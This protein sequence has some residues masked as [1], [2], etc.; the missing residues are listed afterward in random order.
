MN[1]VNRRSV[2]LA[3]LGAAG[4]GALAACTDSTSTPALVS[5]SGSA[6][7]AAAAAAE[8]RRA[9]TGRQHKITLTA[10]PATV[11]LGGGIKVRTWTF[12]GRTPGKEVR[13]SAGDTLAAELANQLPGR[14][15]TSIHW[16]GIALRNDMDGAP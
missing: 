5:P 8:K 2:L 16:H 12:D 13:L 4:A 15:S 9:G 6:V 10:A 1:S 14:T 7:A 11:D 3:G